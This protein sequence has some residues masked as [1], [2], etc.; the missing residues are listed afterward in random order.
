M[1]AKDFKQYIHDVMLSL[2]CSEYLFHKH[3]GK[4]TEGEI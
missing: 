3:N 2:T 1:F 4:H